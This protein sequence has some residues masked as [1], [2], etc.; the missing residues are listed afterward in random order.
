MPDY[1][2]KLFCLKVIVWTH[3]QTHIPDLVLYL[4]IRMVNKDQKDV[5][6]TK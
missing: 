1:I 6:V 4:T 3:K 2:S 5:C